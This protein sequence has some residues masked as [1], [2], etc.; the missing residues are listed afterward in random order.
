MKRRT[1]SRGGFPE[2][3]RDPEGGRANGRA[4]E[5]VDEIDLLVV[6]ARHPAREAIRLTLPEPAGVASGT[7][8]RRALFMGPEG[9]SGS[10]R[11]PTIRRSARPRTPT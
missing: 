6:D 4:A 3:H 5:E 8:R 1:T 11:S 9:Q 2:A 10:F 7:G